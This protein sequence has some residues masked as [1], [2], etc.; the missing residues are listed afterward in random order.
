MVPFYNNVYDAIEIYEKNKEKAQIV[1][2]TSEFYPCFDADCFDQRN[3][4]FKE[5]NQTHKILFHKKYD[6]DYYIYLDKDL[7]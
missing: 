4:L 1:V 6:Q 3:S 7:K 5:I 2:Y